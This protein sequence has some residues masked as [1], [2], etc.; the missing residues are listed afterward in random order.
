MNIVK[1]PY[2]L[3]VSEE[4]EIYSTL[5]RASSLSQAP[6]APQTLRMMAQFSVLSR[7]RD[8]G[9]KSN[10]H[11]KMRAYDGESLKDVDPKAKAIQEYRDDAGVDEGMDGLSTRFAFKILSKTFNYSTNEVAI[12]PVHLMYVSRQEILHLQHERE[13]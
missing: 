13:E 7:L 8:P 1:V 11:S 5:I 9:E 3:R 4:E 10:L 2:C 6:C 12:N